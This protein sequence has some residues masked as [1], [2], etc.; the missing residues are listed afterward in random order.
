MTKPRPVKPT[1]KLS[2]FASSFLRFMKA[3]GEVNV[4]LIDGRTM[5]KMN[6]EFRGQDKATDVLAFP[7]PDDFPMPKGAKRPL[8]DI[9]LNPAYIKKNNE[10]LEYLLTHGILHLLGFNHM[11]KGDKIKMEKLEKQLLAKTGKVS[12]ID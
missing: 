4:Y 1:H 11:K 7:Y 5:R 2:K 8:G 9:Y 3:K 6:R 10:T 12:H